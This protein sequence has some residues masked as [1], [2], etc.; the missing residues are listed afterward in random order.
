MEGMTQWVPIRDFPGISIPNPPSLPETSHREVHTDCLKQTDNFIESQQASA[1][2]LA[3]PI[4]ED[5]ILKFF[6]GVHRPWRRWFARFIDLNLFG[7]IVGISI[8]T[9]L[10][11]FVPAAASQ[12]EIYISNPVL[13]GAMLLLFWMPVECVCISLFRSTPGK[14]RFGIQVSN[15]DGTRL[16]LLESLRRYVGML[17]QGAGLGIPIVVFFTYILS[18]RRLTSTGTTAWDDASKTKVTHVSSMGWR[19]AVAT[20]AVIGSLLF[21]T[22]LRNQT[23]SQ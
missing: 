1:I 17:V 6:G 3:A 12:L 4:P 14:W 20:L 19:Y 23:N 15:P 10:H 7:N 2:G 22:A 21:I 9:V 5:R 13:D 16:N 8:L 11:I 18:Y